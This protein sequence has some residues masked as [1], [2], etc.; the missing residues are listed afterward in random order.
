MPFLSVQFKLFVA[1][2]L[3]QHYYVQKMYGA[4]ELLCVLMF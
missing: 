3:M 2:C 1:V 4:H